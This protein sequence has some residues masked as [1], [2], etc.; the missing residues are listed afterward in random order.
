MITIEDVVGRVV[1]KGIV[2]GV[3][4]VW[5]V[6]REQDV[7]D[8]ACFGVFYSCWWRRCVEGGDDGV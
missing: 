1:N 8:V 5:C 4:L 7:V 6:G 2:T 3:L